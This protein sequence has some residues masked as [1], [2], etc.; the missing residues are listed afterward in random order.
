MKRLESE[1]GIDCESIFLRVLKPALKKRK[2]HYVDA[3]AH[4]EPLHTVG[5]M[6]FDCLDAD[7]EAGGDFFVAVTPCDEAQDFRFALT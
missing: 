7:F 6:C 1:K 4:T 5:F 2:T 3:A